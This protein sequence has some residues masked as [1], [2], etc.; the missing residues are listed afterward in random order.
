[1]KSGLRG[2]A[3]KTREKIGEKMKGKSHSE[4]RERVGFPNA[5]PPPAAPSGSAASSAA[6]K[7]VKSDFE[8]PGN[9]CSF[10]LFLTSSL[11]AS[12]TFS[13]LSLSLSH[14]SLSL[15]IGQADFERRADPKSSEAAA[16][17]EE[18]RAHVKRVS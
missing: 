7:L 10:P 1:V 3:R 5:M 12:V 16:L 15:F 18:M 14:V 8:K 13:F 9:L 17:L 4:E 2:E 11:S 6:E